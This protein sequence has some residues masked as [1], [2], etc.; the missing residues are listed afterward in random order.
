MYKHILV[1]IDPGHGAVGARIIAVARLLTGGAG[2]ITILT[3]VESVPGYLANEVP[4]HLIERSRSATAELIRGLARDSGI[5]PDGVVIRDGNAASM[6]LEEAGRLG[7]DAIILGSHRP[8]FGDY[9]I[10]STASR[11]VRHAQCTV[12]VER[13]EVSA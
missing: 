7:V 6:I 12:V 9:L 5:D 2:R 13:S 4:L 10:G 8:N 1:P 11:V 3:V